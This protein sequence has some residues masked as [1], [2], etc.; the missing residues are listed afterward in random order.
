MTE[1]AKT[2]RMGV[3]GGGVYG[4]AMLK[5][6]AALQ[7]Q[8]LVELVALAETDEA[9]LGRQVGAYG[10]AGYTDYRQMFAHAG[11]DAVAIATPDHLHG[12]LVL[13]A[14]AAG[15]HVLVQKPLD[16]SSARARQMLAAC[17]ARGVLLFVDFHKRFDPAHMRLKSDLQAGRLGK[18]QYG[19]VCMEDQIL[20]PTQ[21]LRKWAARSSPSWFL[22]VHFYDLVYWLLQSRPLR[23][24]ASG[25]RGKLQA[26][27]LDALDSVNARVE[28][29]NGATFSFDLSWILP[30]AFPSIVNQQLRMVGQE[31]L[32]EIDS[33]D[34][35]M[36]SACSD[37][38]ASLVSNPFGA[39][40]YEH[41]V[42][43][44]QVQGYTYASMQRFVELLAAIKSGR[45]TLAQLAGKYPD[46]QD[47]LVSTEIGE[48]VERSI[49]TGTWIAL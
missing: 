13:A 24:Y 39:Q 14:A 37:T 49:A 44:A 35:G 2:P 8:G 19:Y 21:W 9:V 34:R 38:P 7:R 12:D 28:Y 46:G 16:T 23:V 15:L 5:C 42:W 27:G 20:V 43:G 22:G 18:I 11:L 3:A 29:A 33:Q 25:H 1:S 36:F 26:L 10:L 6:F 17:S 48:A 41:P 45:A 40:E 32:V 31:G 4:S 30:A 47:A